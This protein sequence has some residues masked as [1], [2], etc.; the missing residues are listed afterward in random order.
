MITIDSQIWIYYFDPNAQENQNVRLWMNAILKTSEIVLNTIIPIEVS[1]NLYR[2]PKISPDNIEQLIF[3][4][5][6]QKNIKILQI[7]NKEMLNALQIL[8][9]LRSKGIG[10]RDCLILATMELNEVNVLVT[11][12]KNLLSLDY[13]KRIDPVFNPPLI[14]EKG[15]KFNSKQYKERL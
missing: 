11:N 14:L 1:H 12:D 6:T 13:I 9:S 2:I 5:I 15:E 10:G 3:K 8:K 7:S 4:W